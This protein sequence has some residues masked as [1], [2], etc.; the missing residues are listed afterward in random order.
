MNARKAIDLMI[1]CVW[2]A[3]V[4]IAWRYMESGLARNVLIGVAAV[5]M[6]GF[7]VGAYFD[8][9]KQKMVLPSGVSK[10]PSEADRIT[11]LVFLSEEDTELMVWDLY[12][13]VSMVIGRDVKENRVDVDLSCGPYASMADVEHAVMNYSGG[14]WYVEDLGSV[15]GLGIKKAEDGRL[16]RLSADTPCRCV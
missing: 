10:L 13:K 9:D 4:W 12:G 14:D 2:G 1:V 6:L 15:N 11:E 3:I 8:K 5:Y 16:Y 7:A